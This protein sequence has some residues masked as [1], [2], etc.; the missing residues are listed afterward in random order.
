M[1]RALPFLCILI[2]VGVCVFLLFQRAPSEAVSVHRA[3]ARAHAYYLNEANADYR[4]ARLELEAVADR[5]GT[6]VAFHVDMALID[7]AETNHPVQ[8]ES[9]LLAASNDQRL[10][11]SA[12]H[13]LDLAR[14]LDPA[15]DAVAFNLARTYLKLAPGAE[16]DDEL[17]G[18]AE[19]L[20]RP[21]TAR[22]PPDP[23]TLVLLGD[24]LW[25]RGDREG[26]GRLY[27]RIAELG[28]EDAV[29]DTIHFVA[30]N[31][32]A[33]LLERTDPAAAA[34][35]RRRIDELFPAKPEPTQA[36]LERG[37]HT[38]FREITAAP[39]TAPQ[40]APVSWERVTARTG[41]PQPGPGF[42][43]LIAPDID[44]DCARDLVL[45]TAGGLRVFRN[46]GSAS[47]TDLTRQAGLPESLVL[48]AAAAGDIDNDGR[49][50][51]AVGGPA[52]L[53]VF[54]NH[55]DSDEPTR[56]RFMPAQPLPD[57]PPLF[58]AGATQPVSCLVLWDLDQDGDLDLFAG[59]PE[60]NRVYRLAIE[61]PVDGGKYL[62]YEDVT[63]QVGMA[64]PPATDALVLD[65]EDDHDVD[66]LV[67]GSQGNAWFANLRQMRFEKRELPGGA[68]LG[69]GDADN[70]LREEVRVGRG[71]YR[72]EPGGWRQLFERDALV[73][74]DGDGVLEADPLAGIPLAG[75][76]R[77]VVGTDLNGD[78]SRDL[79]LHTGS[80]LDIFLAP[81]GRAT[82]W[83]AIQLRGLA[84][85]GLG[86]GTRLRLFA[87]D[88][89]IGATCRDGL[90]SFGLGHRPVVDALLVRWTNGVEQGVVTPRIAACVF[91]EERKGEPGP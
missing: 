55:T 57:G 13:H 53:R 18:R 44:G 76:I 90:V 52:G 16:N 70:D 41:L 87:G 60:S 33:Q 81:P 77:R 17:R 56:W 83:L 59:G 73:D 25:E 63:G 50:D 11:R 27:A 54:L 29:T 82:A 31:K 51:L 9:R 68:T 45:N 2:L 62:R 78:G 74:L 46:R 36:A 21:L 48:S 1:R 28:V 64:A 23:S 5:L 88:L 67:A 19:D 24:L 66:L 84:T 15:S 4:R 7:L 10:L 35:R 58:G 22:Q 26:A 20:L 86:I 40:P 38:A 80:R 43:G 39:A 6:S 85:N 32:L 30:L 37:R 79:I 61:L 42:R 69:A 8:G 47:F 72:W 3:F 91:V 71:I 65:V 49:C 12:L 34:E 75:G 89:R 14:A